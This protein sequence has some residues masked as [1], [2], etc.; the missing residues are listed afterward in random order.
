MKLMQYLVPILMLAGSASAATLP[1]QLTISGKQFDIS[2][3]IYYQADS[4]ST[5]REGMFAGKYF[6]RDAGSVK[7]VYYPAQGQTQP[8][9]N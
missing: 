8:S 7:L 1:F 4:L 9:V 3:R 5:L 2:K 6:D